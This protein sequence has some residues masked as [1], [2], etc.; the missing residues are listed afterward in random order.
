[1]KWLKGKSLL[2]TSFKTSITLK[3]LDGLLEIVGGF[4][5]LLVSPA[6]VNTLVRSVT[7]HAL[8]R[9]PHDFIASHLLHASQS[10]NGHAQYFAFFYLVSHGVAKVF[11]VVALWL[12]RLWAY[13]AMIVLLLLF[14]AY[15]S[16]RIT[17]A[18]SWWLV[19]LTLFDIFVIWL[20]WEEYK[21]QRASP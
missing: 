8:S 5:F 12:N 9:N 7:Q 19:A 3:G 18:P 21:K 2:D 15:Q 10:F 16:Y 4:L 13:P 1:M 20:T 17:F 14:I 11:L 6:R